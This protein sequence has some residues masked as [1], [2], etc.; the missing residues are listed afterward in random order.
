MLLMAL[1]SAHIHQI[2]SFLGTSNTGTAQGLILSQIYPIQHQL[3]YLSLKLLSLL[4]ITSI[5]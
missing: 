3:L 5:D 1:Q 2:L 4:E